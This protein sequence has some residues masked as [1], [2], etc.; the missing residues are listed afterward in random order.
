MTTSIF[1][2]TID[3]GYRDSFVTVLEKKAY[4]ATFES[5]LEVYDLGIENEYLSTIKISKEAE[6]LAVGYSNT[7]K[8]CVFKDARKI[9]EKKLWKTND[10]INAI[11][12]H[13]VNTF[14]IA[15]YGS[16][17][18]Y[19]LFDIRTGG[20][21][22]NYNSFS[23]IFN[24]KENPKKDALAF[25]TVDTLHMHIVD[26]KMPGRPFIG[27]TNK[28]VVKGV[29]W[30]PWDSNS[31]LTGSGINE[32]KIREWSLHDKKL[33]RECGIGREITGLLFSKTQERIHCL[34]WT[35]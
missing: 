24:I 3:W 22:S 17:S 32:R 29:A 23:W 1:E 8:V 27:L 10:S 6:M 35:S 33:V 9:A 31:I 4:F 19:G 5:N 16:N 12:M 11:E 26:I 13:D 34:V 2:T 7:S 18:S 14:W 28:S 15:T 25:S 20:L 21:V 30:C